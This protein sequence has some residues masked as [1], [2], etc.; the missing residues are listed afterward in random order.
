MKTRIIYL[1]F[2]FIL[3][4]TGAFAKK[5]KPAEMKGWKIMQLQGNVKK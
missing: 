2:S 3:I 4:S 5:L 1:L